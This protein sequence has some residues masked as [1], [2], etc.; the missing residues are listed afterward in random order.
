MFQLFYIV[1]YAR[2]NWQKVPN[3]KQEYLKAFFRHLQKLKKGEQIDKDSGLHHW[4]HLM[5]NALF[6]SY[7]LQKE[8]EEGKKEIIDL[9]NLEGII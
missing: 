7:F 3:G 2:N 4:H 1:K 9:I 6:V 5:C 8:A